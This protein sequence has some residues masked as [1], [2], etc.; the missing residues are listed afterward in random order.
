MDGNPRTMSYTVLA[1]KWRP[2]RFAEVVG[3]QHVVQALV[4]SLAAERLHHAYLFAGTRGVGKTTVARILAKALNCTQGV[5]AEPCGECSACVAIDE[6][7]FVDLIEVD[8]ASRTRVDDTRE[9][10]DNV[11][12]APTHGRYKVYLIDE[13]HML[14]NHSFNALLKTLEEPPPHVK[15]LLATTDPQKLPVTV[16]SRCL[17]FN[18]KRLSIALIQEQLERICADEGVEAEPD[19]LRALAKGADGSVRDAL[20]LLDQ[21]IAF[22]GNRVTRDAVESMLGTID[23]GHLIKLL[24]GLAAA[25]GSVLMNEVAELDE[26]APNYASVLDGLM[27][28]LQRLAVIQLV[29]GAP[30]E[31][32]DEA[33]AELAAA[34]S[35]EDVQ[36][37][38]QIALQG[39]RDLAACADW[40]SAFEMTLLR[41]LAFRPAAA[42]EPAGVDTSAA[43]SAAGASAPRPAPA[44]ARP[45]GVERKAASAPVAAAEDL[46]SPREQASPARA[47]NAGESLTPANWIALLATADMRGAARQLAEH[48]VVQRHA[49]GKI[50]L[51][52][53]KDKAHLN[54]DQVRRRLE[55]R[56]AEHLGQSLKLTVSVG[57]PPEPTPAEQRQANETQRMRQARESIEQDPTVRGF[58][59]AFDAVVEADSIEPIEAAEGTAKR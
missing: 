50:D 5:V 55:A 40:R 2:K 1:R 18:L 54:T 52:L 27:G 36:L 37:Y 10:L 34:I 47:A 17:Q 58:Q 51:V 30:A 48:C 49:D 15:F 56:L 31:D 11:Q 12:Y 21:A 20:S 44:R 8:A 22:G 43:S 38:Y 23:R 53:A 29:G 57:K 14:S 26:Q 7:R 59:T 35:P 9:L 28:V 16:L 32:D 24:Q 45:R 13:V 25:D 6:G 4:N 3:Q 42:G 39:R 41:M 33:L 46:P 19:A